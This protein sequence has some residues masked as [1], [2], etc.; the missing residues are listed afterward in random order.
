MIQEVYLL[1]D[2]NASGDL[3]VIDFVTI[4]STGNST[5]FGDLLFTGRYKTGASNQTRGVIFAGK[6]VISPNAGKIILIILR[7]HRQAMQMILVI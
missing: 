6:D 3:N 4:A 1:E 2:L 5:D 7:L